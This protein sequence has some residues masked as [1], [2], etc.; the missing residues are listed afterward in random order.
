MN[1]RHHSPWMKDFGDDH[2]D[3]I[4]DSLGQRSCNQ[5]IA[6]LRSH[7]MGWQ[8]FYHT[9]CQIKDVRALWQ[10]TIPC[11]RPGFSHFA[12]DSNVAAHESNPIVN[13]SPS[14]S[15]NSYQIIRSRSL[16]LL[17]LLSR[18][19]A[20]SLYISGYFHFFS[21]HEIPANS[22]AQSLY[23]GVRSTPIHP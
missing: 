22:R 18:F 19:L 5:L 2:A 16:Y 9:S 13:H 6:F 3:Y 15:P 11:R 8:I 1:P 17:S 14:H 20:T 7:I 4:D 10:F 23:I 21:H 12:W